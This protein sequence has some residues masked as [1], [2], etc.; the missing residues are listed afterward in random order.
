MGKKNWQWWILGAV[1]VIGIA[2]TFFVPPIPQDP[3]YHEFA[4]RRMFLGIPNFWNVFSNLPFVIFGAYGLFKFS[5]LREPSFRHAYL[6]FCVGI[7]FVGF[8]SAYYHYSPSTE[9]LLWDRLPMTI[10]FM[11]LFS[12]I[13]GDRVSERFGVMMLLPLLITGVASV[14]YWYWTETQGRGDLRAYGLVQFLPMLLIPLMLII[15]EG[16]GL[17]VPFV[18][19]TLGTYALA[20]LTEVFDKAIYDATGFMSGHA[21][22]HALASIAVL[23]AIF[24][25]LKF[26]PLKRVDY[27]SN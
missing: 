12:M 14:V 26:N 8:G 23:W 6:I 21:I 15:C 19:A 18:W 25:I 7:I 4:D 27:T 5:L 24:A 1:T 10:V 9:T 3:A 16:K 2:A 20:K 11:A 13:L 17:R 22:K